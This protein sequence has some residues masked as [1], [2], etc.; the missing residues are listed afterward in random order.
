MVKESDAEKIR[1]LSKTLKNFITS[2]GGI[3]VT[4]IFIL[5]ILN[6]LYIA[7]FY[8]GACESFEC[9]QNSMKECDK[10]S[11]VNDEPEA[12]W[13]Y[14]ILGKEDNLCVVDVKLLQAKKGE[15]GID[16]I[17]G[18]SMSCYYPIGIG[19][20]PEKDLSKCHGRLKE[21]LQRIVIEKLHSN[22]LENLGEI[23][24][25]INSLL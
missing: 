12:S 4:I 18:Y 17:T 16:K 25:V 14:Q 6:G 3:I 19:T 2:K 21:E 10:V 11:Y 23:E 8:S 15:L 13:K 20:Y 22:I 5:I 7:F 9:F 1:K 24:D